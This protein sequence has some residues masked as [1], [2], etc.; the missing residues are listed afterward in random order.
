MSR[1]ALIGVVIAI[2]VAG[3][4]LFAL[5][6]NS[7]PAAPTNQSTTEDHSHESSEEQDESTTEESDTKSVSIVSNADDG[8]APATI[9][10][11]KGETV[12][13]TN[14]D[15]MPHTVEF[16]DEESNELSRGDTFSKQFDSVGTFSYE[17][18][19]HSNM[20]GTVVVEE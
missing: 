13:W 11:K 17:C 6:N 20:T 10:I 16:D 9:T 3:G 5:T 12:T 8:F 18:G 7:E 1:G 14:N 4:V 19:L 15:D 2:L